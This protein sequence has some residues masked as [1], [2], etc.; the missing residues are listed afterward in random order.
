[1]RKISAVTFDLWD[2]LIQELPGEPDKVSRG[3][4]DGIQ[5][6]LERKGIVHTRAEIE[7]AYIDTG[8]FLTLTWSKRRDMSTRDQVLFML[9]SLDDK[10]TPKLAPEDLVGEGRGVEEI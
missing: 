3:R 4:N 6:L 7:A 8:H 9:N 5:R 10:L 1:M 2:T